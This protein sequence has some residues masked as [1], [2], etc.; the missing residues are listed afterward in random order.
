MPGD[1]E[2]NVFSLAIQAGADDRANLIG[3]HCEGLTSSI[4]S[5]VSALPSGPLERSVK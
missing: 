4:S 2:V 3:G 1:V 5:G